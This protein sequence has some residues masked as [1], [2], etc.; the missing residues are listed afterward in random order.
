MGFETLGKCFPVLKNRICFSPLWERFGKF[1][2]W[3]ED[4]KKNQII[5]KKDPNTNVFVQGKS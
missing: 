5:S 1:V 3:S 4:L 2:F